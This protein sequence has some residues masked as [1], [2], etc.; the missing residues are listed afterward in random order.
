MVPRT[1]PAGSTLSARKRLRRVSLL[2]RAFREGDRAAGHSLVARFN[3]YLSLSVGM[4][5][6]ER[7]ALAN[8]ARTRNKAARELAKTKADAQ[9]PYMESTREL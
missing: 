2:S 4:P 1:I 7:L 5:W 3:A 6:P 9:R 8:A